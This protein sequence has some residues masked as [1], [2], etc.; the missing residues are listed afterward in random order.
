MKLT[1]FLLVKV[2][3]AAGI[4]DDLREQLLELLRADEDDCNEGFT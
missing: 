4:A 1:F 2:F 3:G